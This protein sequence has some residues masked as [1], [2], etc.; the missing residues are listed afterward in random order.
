MHISHIHKEA[1]SE[2]MVK[3]NCHWRIKALLVMTKEYLQVKIQK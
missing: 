3:K 1:I 2:F